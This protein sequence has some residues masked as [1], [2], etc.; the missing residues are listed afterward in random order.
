MYLRWHAFSLQSQLLKSGWT[1]LSTVTVLYRLFLAKS[2]GNEWGSER[3]SVMVNMSEV[4]FKKSKLRDRWLPRERR[5]A[6][7]GLD[8]LS[9]W[10]ALLFCSDVSLWPPCFALVFQKRAFSLD[11]F[12][13]QIFRTSLRTVCRIDFHLPAFLS[14]VS[15]ISDTSARLSKIR[16][17]ELLQ[18]VEAFLRHVAKILW[19]LDEIQLN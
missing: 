3:V 10:R 11:P 15:T 14:N 4:G 7:D 1:L 6:S 19:P 16:Y 18:W 17:S 12:P 9:N 5:W 2:W 8:F 13:W